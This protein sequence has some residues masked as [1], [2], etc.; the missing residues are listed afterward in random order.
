VGKI[1][2]FITDVDGVL[3]DGGMYYSANGD[4][5]KKFSTQDG[6]GMR[7]LM[8][9]GIKTAFITGEDTPIVANRAEKLQINYLFMGI[10]DKLGIAGEI[11]KKEN[12]NIDETAFIGDDLWDITLLQKA[13]I[14]ACPDNA[15]KIVKEIP[16]IILLKKKGG[17]G[18]VREF[19]DYLFD[20]NLLDVRSF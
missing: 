8:D 18:A 10:K 4:E 7:I 16:G 20:N 19:I 6:M 1:K 3:T 12:I 14:A 5:M 13:G 15:V 17:D 11:C 2:L 9:A